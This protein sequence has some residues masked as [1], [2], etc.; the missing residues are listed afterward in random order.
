MVRTHLS[1]DAYRIAPA[2][3]LALST[4]IALHVLAA[5]LLLI[6][7]TYRS[8][9]V[10]HERMQVRWQLPDVIPPPTPPPPVDPV[11][12][13]HAPPPV[14]PAATAPVEVP[15]P[16]PLPLLA[17]D[18][19]GEPAPPAIDAAPTLAPFD[20][21]APPMAGVQLQYLKAPPPPYPREALRDRL[22]GTVLLRV[23][24]G[25]DG[26]PLEVTVERSSGH[27]TLDAAAR[28]QVLRQWR[29][30]PATQA[31]QPSQGY[32]LVPVAFSLN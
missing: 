31:G 8:P 2:R 15:V 14:P 6:P 10:Q 5:A 24:V 25:V 9:P 21:V 30:K 20:T 27:R 12:V 23:L 7:A 3:I 13:Q 4:A 29:F 18:T 26:R 16:Q 1:S 28:S 22:E 17:S 32:G 19:S 11:P